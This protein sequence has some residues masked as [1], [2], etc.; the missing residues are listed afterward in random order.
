MTDD[1]GQMAR[2]LLDIKDKLLELSKKNSQIGNYNSQ[3]EEIEK[4]AQYAESFKV[5][6]IKSRN[7]R[8]RYTGFCVPAKL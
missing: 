4:F 5:N 3:V 6:F 2:T 1:E 8:K 7:L